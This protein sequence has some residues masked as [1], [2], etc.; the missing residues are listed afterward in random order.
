MVT[1]NVLP[2]AIS[3][4]WSGALGLHHAPAGVGQSTWLL[5]TIVHTS[6]LAQP[7]VCG[8][9]AV[10]PAIDAITDETLFLGARVRN[11]SAGWLH[12]EGTIIGWK[13]TTGKAVGDLW[14]LGVL[15]CCLVES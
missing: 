6:Q 13:A 14:W 2:S 12:G 15:A 5:I 7:C 11:N 8:K 3:P 4:I 10:P 1:G 9:G